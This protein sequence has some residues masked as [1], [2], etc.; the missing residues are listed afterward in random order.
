MAKRKPGEGTVFRRKDG[1][2]VARIRLESGK[3]KQRYCKTEKEARAALRK[4]LQ[5]QEQ[6]TLAT[7]PQHVSGAVAGA[8][9]QALNYPHRD[10]QCLPHRD[11]QAH[12]PDARAY[13]VAEIDASTHPGILRQEN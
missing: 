2:W 11:L 12:H 1:R 4:M 5:E 9:T 10:L 6:G 3:A 13:P 8:G 7:G